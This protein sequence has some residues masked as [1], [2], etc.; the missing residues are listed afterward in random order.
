MS[1]AKINN[2]ATARFFNRFFDQTFFWNAQEASNKWI[3]WHTTEERK[4]KHTNKDDQM[5][6]L[7]IFFAVSTCSTAVHNFHNLCERQFFYS[8]TA[9]WFFF[10]GRYDTINP[11]LSQIFTYVTVSVNVVR[12]LL[13]ACKQLSIK[14]RISSISSIIISFASMKSL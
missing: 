3:G 4:P 14:V 8:F 1:I 6:F 12:F 2:I 7:L 5:S 13:S 11:L 9:T 10:H